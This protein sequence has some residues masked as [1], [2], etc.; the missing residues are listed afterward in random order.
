MLFPTLL[1]LGL[2]DLGKQ[3]HQDLRGLEL[4]AKMQLEWCPLTQWKQCQESAKLGATLRVP[5]S[6]WKCC[7]VQCPVP[8]AV[9]KGRSPH[10]WQGAKVR[11]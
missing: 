8:S 1:C 10:C 2:L 11:R 4:L 3:M 7:D 5:A 6:G 9:Q